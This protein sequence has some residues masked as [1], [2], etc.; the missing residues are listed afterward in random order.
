MQEQGQ[1]LF[2]PFRLDLANES[3]W[4]ER[5]EIR[6]HPK[7]FALLRFLVERAGQTV[8][9][10]TLLQAVWPKVYVTDAVLSVYIAEIRKALGDD[11]KEPKFI[12]TM[13]R[14]GYR[15]I[16]AITPVP[17][18]ASTETAAASE[19]TL[20]PM[21]REAATM[22][23]SQPLVGR[24]REIAL[25]QE[26]LEAALQGNGNVVLITGQAGIGK[27]RLVRELR[28]HAAGK[29]FQWLEGKYN[30]A[31]SHP[32][33]AWAEAAR[34][35]L[36]RAAPHV[37]DISR[38]HLAKIV[39]E[40]VQTAKGES[41]RVRGDPD[42]ER[43][44]LF[45]GLTQFFIHLSRES[46]LALFLDDVQWASSIDLLHYLSRSIGS[47]KVLTLA[48]YRDDEL[49]E[50]PNLPSTVLA[51]NRE[52]LF[53]PLP[54]KPLEQTEV[55]QLMSRTLEKNITSQLVDV[56]YRKTEGNPFFVEEVLRL[57]QER[58]AFVETDQGW[59][60]KEPASLE[61]P[62]SVK[63]IINERLERL[64][65]DAEEQ[66]RMASVIGREFP[67]ELL[68][69][70]IGESE[71][72]LV[73]V[74]DRCEAA[75]LI[76]P[77]REPGQEIY[78]F[79]HDLMY[80]AL[81]E[82]IGTARRKRQHLSI[83]QAIETLY[84]KKL[85]DRYDALAHH[86]F[87]GNDLEQALHYSELAAERA[88]SVHAYNR[89]V[90][91]L[92][93][94]LEVQAALEPDN[95]AKRCNLLLTLGGVL[96]PAGEPKKAADTVAPEGLGLAEQ[97]DDRRRAS[98][99]CRMALEALFRY[100]GPVITR[101]PAWR[102]W[103]ERAPH[104]AA[105]GTSDQV[106]ADIA[107]SRAYVLQR[108]WSEARKRT[109]RA[110]E[111]ARKLDEPEVLSRGIFVLLLNHAVRDH[112]EQLSL[113]EEFMRIRKNGVSAATVSRLLLT[114][115]GIFLAAGKRARAEEA[116]RELDQLASHTHDAGT[117]IW[118][119]LAGP[120]RA[121]LDGKLEQAVEARASIIGRA[122]ELGISGAGR[123]AAD[124]FSFRP[125]L[126]LGRA[127]EALAA[128]P[129]AERLVG[130]Q[131]FS[132]T[133]RFGWSALCLAHMGRLAEARAQLS[134][135]LG[136]SKLSVEEDDTPTVILATL[137]EIAVLVE[138]REAVSMLAKRLTGIVAL[139]HSTN[140]HLV[141][142]ARHL[143][144]AALLLGN[145]KE[146]RTNY[147][148]ALDWATK[149]RFRP[150]IALTRF[151]IAK[152]LLAEAKDANGSRAAAALRSEGQGHLDFAIG[153]FQAMKMKPA[154]EQALQQQKL[155]SDLQ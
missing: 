128:L 146:A 35:Y 74:M 148:R 126:F 131:A 46:P 33:E 103:A 45:E 92:E 107:L 39:P 87:E 22:I 44:R 140:L 102:Q 42:D 96:G 59:E 19:A 38:V 14:R 9:K 104:Y 135:Y 49:K 66:L 5:K 36:Q 149:I 84:A 138:D 89:A 155:L 142:V 73:E 52:R 152:L 40:L 133:L 31:E 120:I 1:F 147:E 57:L 129:E 43:F 24:G 72:K 123:L 71:D 122:D 115:Q 65:K 97:L 121:K 60:V 56:I 67:L 118:P 95:R 83:G 20:K 51:M 134:E 70:V 119:V 34:S 18:P 94:A 111:L 77:K 105:P 136:K 53:H 4:R 116:W 153:E 7:A 143:G 79:T 91:L 101:S 98:Q 132:S 26:R 117:L 137:L 27:T 93:H 90:R 21:S 144:R 112:P 85:E 15:F 16:A 23:G 99:F 80:E 100:G 88:I 58:R 2:G 106:I 17:Q 127:E 124:V 25:L 64:G 76:I 37:P 78:G 41:E 62:E 145:R 3:L 69:Q 82:S 10:E 108:Q 30:K 141:N 75:G 125:L 32:Y 139:G 11:P 55:A 110:V 54:L 114:S 47:Q 50:R 48:A 61:T 154:L 63:A 68:R 12:E 6:L 8:S 151:E 130:S 13:H 150:E 113:V 109:V 29:G 81:Y 86:F 28:H